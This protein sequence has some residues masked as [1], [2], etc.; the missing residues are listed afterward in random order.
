MAL[1]TPGVPVILR[2][3]VAQAKEAQLASQMPI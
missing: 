1:W 3:C 2:P